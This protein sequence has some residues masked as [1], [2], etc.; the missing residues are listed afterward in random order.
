MRFSTTPSPAARTRQLRR[1]ALLLALLIAGGLLT[2]GPL[3]PQAHAAGKPAPASPI[4]YAPVFAPAAAPQ[5]AAGLDFSK[6]FLNTGYT[7]AIAS[8]DVNGD[9]A[10]DLLAGTSDSS[11]N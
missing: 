11:G 8:G 9:G 4:A 5:A 1:L 10:L 3:A 6:I 2:A 7:L